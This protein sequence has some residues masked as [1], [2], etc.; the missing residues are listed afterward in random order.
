MAGKTSAVQRQP[1]STRSRLGKDLFTVHELKATAACLRSPAIRVDI[2]EE[3]ADARLSGAG[4]SAPSTLSCH[5]AALVV[6]DTLCIVLRER[7]RRAMLGRPCAV[8]AAAGRPAALPVAHARAGVPCRRWLCTP[9]S[10]LS[11]GSRRLL[12]IRAAA[13]RPAVA[14]A[15]QQQLAEAEVEPADV[16]MRSEVLQHSCFFSC[17]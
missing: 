15:Q 12:H 11:A 2:E 17:V 10:R 4:R 5:S 3:E 16:A 14:K 13:C 8:P 9:Q 1:Q 6:A 7:S